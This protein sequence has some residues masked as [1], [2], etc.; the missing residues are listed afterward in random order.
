MF[1]EVNLILNQFGQVGAVRMY[2]EDI[3]R[4]GCFEMGEIN[5]Y[6]LNCTRE[7]GGDSEYEGVVRTFL[8][9]MWLLAVVIM[10]LI[11]L[12]PIEEE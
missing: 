9:V 2:Y 10:L 11:V 3:G 5:E 8:Y 6:L 4:A 7:L 1:W 12:R